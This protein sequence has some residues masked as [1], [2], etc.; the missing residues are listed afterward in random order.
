[1]TTY[2][3]ELGASY[4]ELTFAGC[5]RAGIA[6]DQE[7]AD[8]NSQKAARN[9]R[10]QNLYN[11]GVADQ[12]IGPFYGNVTGWPIAVELPGGYTLEAT[13]SSV[14]SGNNES[15]ALFAEDFPTYPQGAFLGNT[16]G[17]NSFYTGV[18]GKPAIYNN[19]NSPGNTK[20][21]L[22]GIQEKLQ[23]A[24]ELQKNLGSWLQT[25]NRL[26][27]VKVFRGAQP[28]MVSDGCQT[29]QGLAPRPNC[30]LWATLAMAHTRQV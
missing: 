1:M 24:P 12:D 11:S 23:T 22:G 18:D 3:S 8:T 29:A 21:S 16:L 13:V 19:F 17:G 10:N 9:N 25:Q 6:Y 7:R 14:G 27:M 15:K 28:E 26:T 4:G 30:Q 20:V 5:G 2:V